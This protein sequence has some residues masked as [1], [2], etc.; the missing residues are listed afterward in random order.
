MT[1]K[2]FFNSL[3]PLSIP[4]SVFYCNTIWVVEFFLFSNIWLSDVLVFFSIALHD[5]KRYDNKYITTMY[6]IYR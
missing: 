1:N 3:P 5:L 6:I 2:E 4:C